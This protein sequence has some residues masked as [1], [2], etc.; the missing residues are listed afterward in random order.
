MDGVKP[1]QSLH[2]KALFYS[3][4][5]PVFII[6]SILV[7]LFL[8]LIIESIPILRQQGLSTFTS[9][10]W[11]PSL[12]DTPPKVEMFRI[13][14]EAPENA[15]AWYGLLP[16]ILGTFL[17]SM[18]AVFL[19]LPF[20][21]SLVVFMEELLPSRFKE[22]VTLAIDL[23]AGLPT[24][25]FGLWGLGFLGPLLKEY[26]ATPLHNYLWFIPL[27]S[28][29]PLSGYNALTAGV[30]LSIMITPFMTALIQEAYR[31]IPFT[32]REAALSIGLTRYEYIS[33]NLSMIS[34]A[35]ISATLLGLGRAM[36][37]TAAVALV[38]GN[39]YNPTFCLLNPTFTVTSLIVNKFAESDLYPYMQ[40]ALFAGGLILLVIGLVINTLGILLMRRVRF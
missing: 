37:E 39:I 14:L 18:V 38:V 32:Y 13:L 40:S 2:D 5:I 22:L 16:A 30:L 15:K 36:S 21:I 25:L 26:I 19:A 3:L 8:T 11:K 24:I 1:R 7:V 29:T 31:A 9:I 4:T 27:F 20:S 23:T 6:T 17:T 35:V 28:C 12:E 33:L 34:P 10:G